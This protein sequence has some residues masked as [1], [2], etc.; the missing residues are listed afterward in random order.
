MEQERSYELERRWLDKSISCFISIKKELLVDKIF[1][2]YCFITTIV[3]YSFSLYLDFPIKYS[4]T[5]YLET[6]G[7][8]IYIVGVFWCIYYYFYLLI[9]KEPQPLKKFRIKIKQIFFPLSK[10]ISFCISIIFL[11]LIFSNHTFLKSLIPT[12]NSFYW[13]HQ[14]S[15]IDKIIHFGYTPWEITHT[16]FSSPWTSLMINVAYNAWF[17]VMWGVLIFFLIY[18]KKLLLRQQFLLTFVLSWMILGIFLATLLSS[19]GP[20]FME[21]ITGDTRYVPLM[22]KLNLQSQY[23]TSIDLGRLWALST[24]EY[25]W[26]EYITSTNSI[27]S[28]ISAMPSMHVS[29]AILMA[30]STY[31]INKKVGYIFYLFAVVIQIGSVHLG[32]HYAIDGYVSIIF[33]ILLW[34]IVGNILIN[35]PRTSYF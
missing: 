13:D 29:I 19:A 24:Q 11:N 8:G 7:A 14:F 31:R 16:V 4:F 20:C 10:P 33:T 5:T 18:K 17:F 30:L 22:D 34:K 1:Y 27:G 6:L 28:G 35:K 9:K 2:L 3:I 23:L 32:W 15:D 25:L 26:H 12:M 21:L